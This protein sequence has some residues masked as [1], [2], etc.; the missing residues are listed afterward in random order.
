MLEYTPAASTNM[1]AGIVASAYHSMG[2]KVTSGNII[3]TLHIS[4]DESPLFLS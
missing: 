2:S 3:L 4:I 1:I